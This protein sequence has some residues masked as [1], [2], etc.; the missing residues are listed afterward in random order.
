MSARP[1]LLAVVALL[2]S[3]LGPFR[4]IGEAQAQPLLD[5][6][7]T[8]TILNR[9]TQVA[10]DGSFAIPNVP[11]DVG[12]LF[13]VR[14]VCDRDGELVRGQSRLLDLV[15]NGET[16]LVPAGV[17]DAQPISFDAFT[18]IPRTLRLFAETDLTTFTG[19]GEMRQL[20]TVA[21]MADGQVVDM[22][23]S[24]TGTSYS[25]SNP[26]VASVDAEGLVTAHRRGSVV[27]QARNEGVVGALDLQI[28]IPDDADGDGMTDSW[29]L[30][31]PSPSGSWP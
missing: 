24:D 7:C 19:V 4:G 2:V 21:T 28:L 25:S 13:R 10:P 11:V 29:R 14:V 26:G 12:G 16:P 3:F 27:V 9:S 15:A 22:T 17:F 1:G 18:P 20:Y 23:G 30:V 6:N 8:A 5:E 31:R